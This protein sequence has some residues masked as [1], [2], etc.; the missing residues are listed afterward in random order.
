MMVIVVFVSLLLAGPTPADEAASLAANGEAHLQRAATPGDH[1]LDEFEGAHKNF[2]SAYLVGDDPRYLCRA[3]QVTEVVLARVAF[4]SDQERLSWVELRDDD[5][6]RLKQDAAKTRRENC[7]FDASAAPMLRRVAMLTDAD[8]PRAEPSSTALER[9]AQPLEPTRPIPV[10]RGAR[11]QTA[12]GAT[13]TG[14]GLGLVG[15][16]AGAIGLQAQQAAAMR[17]IFDRARAAGELSDLDRDRADDLR[18][19]SVQ[20]RN[21]AL[22]GGITGAATLATGITLLAT[23]KRAARRF[24][25]LPHGGPF[26]GGATLRLRF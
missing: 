12:V 9:L 24:A 7:R 25:V 5:L 18:A 22:A 23:G 4:A 10:Q 15:L 20:T 11:A 21:V 26:G 2:D 6:A 14:L 19:D 16:M 1:Q 3:L 13:F 17:S 8:A